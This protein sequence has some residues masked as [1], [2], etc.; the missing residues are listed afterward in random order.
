M[1]GVKLSIAEMRGKGALAAASHQAEEF[2]LD[3]YG[4]FR[5]GMR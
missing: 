1:I 5:F 4:G 2:A 3:R